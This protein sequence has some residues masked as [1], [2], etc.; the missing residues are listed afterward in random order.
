MNAVV[1]DFNSRREGKC[2]AFLPR[3]PFRD[4]WLKYG[5]PRDSGGH[6]D[7]FTTAIALYLRSESVRKDKIV[8]SGCKPVN[9]ND[10]NLNFA[11]Y[12]PNG[13]IGTPI[14]ATAEL[15]EILWKDVVESVAD[16]F[17]SISKK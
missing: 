13:V 17:H 1:D 12:S 16:T 6:A 5:D 14:Y 10:T 4:I 8:N 2:W 11:D 15:G 9:W 7:S 3:H